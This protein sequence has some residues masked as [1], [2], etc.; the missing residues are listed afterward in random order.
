MF[1]NSSTAIVNYCSLQPYVWVPIRRTRYP[2]TITWHE[3]KRQQDEEDGKESENNELSY[4]TRDRYFSIRDI[5]GNFERCVYFRIVF[6]VDMCS[7][8]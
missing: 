1:N 3:I 5:V 6:S 7:K 8:S 2:S 4:H